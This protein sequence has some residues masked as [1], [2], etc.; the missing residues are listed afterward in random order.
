VTRFAVALLTLAA[1]GDR[2]RSRALWNAHVGCE[3]GD[4]NGC[5][6]E[7]QLADDHRRQEAAA[8]RGCDGG[9]GA[10]CAVLGRLVAGGVWVRRDEA[11]A[12]KLWQRACELGDAG[13]CTLFGNAMWIGAG[14][15]EDH[16]KALALFGR[17]CDAGDPRGCHE[18]ALS[19]EHAD[20]VPRDLDHATRLY[21]TAC[22]GGLKEACAR[23]A[24]ISRGQ[25]SP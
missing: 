25:G 9:S 19:Y 18:L 7:A 17:A 14:V 24:D 22:T 15:K 6:R 4:A 12:A 21:Q 20:G 2:Q 16:G 3:R 1:C 23:L 10:A 11:K 5:A 8:K 13:G